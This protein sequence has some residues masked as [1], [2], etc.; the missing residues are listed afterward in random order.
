[1][2]PFHKLRERT[3]KPSFPWH[4]A[5]LFIAAVSP[6]GCRVLQH[7]RPLGL[8]LERQS[9]Q[10][11]DGFVESKKVSIVFR[12]ELTAGRA[13]RASF[14]KTRT[15]P[16]SAAF[17]GQNDSSRETEHVQVFIRRLSLGLDQGNQQHLI[18]TTFGNPS[19]VRDLT[20]GPYHALMSRTLWGRFEPLDYFV[21]GHPFDTW[22]SLPLGRRLRALGSKF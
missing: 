18:S 19:E 22:A 10:A 9:S 14:T 21:L 8:V 15:P 13:S 2:R 16:E 3:P 12:A 6:I 11:K 20:G 7:R 4:W 17:T 5:H 1:Q